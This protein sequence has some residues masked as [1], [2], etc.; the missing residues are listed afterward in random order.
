MREDEIKRKLTEI[1]EKEAVRIEKHN[2]GSWIKKKVYLGR[3]ILKNQGSA[4]MDEM[5]DTIEDFGISMD[6]LGSMNPDYDQ[7]NSIYQAILSYRTAVRLLK[8]LREHMETFRN[9]KD[10]RNN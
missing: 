4:D 6:N 2:Q 8:R 7:V 1:W 3:G 10:W 9:L 5:F